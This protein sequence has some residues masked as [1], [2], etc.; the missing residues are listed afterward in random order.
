MSDFL[1]F[2]ILKKQC[3][4][5]VIKLENK[6]ISR[7]FKKKLTKKDFA[8]TIINWAK[9]IKYFLIKLNKI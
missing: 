8:K 4:F 6:R 5:V 1:Y 3:Y 2:F 9:L 7:E